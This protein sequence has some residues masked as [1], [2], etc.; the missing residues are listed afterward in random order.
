MQWKNLYPQN[1]ILNKMLAKT[2]VKMYVKVWRTSSD[3]WWSGRAWNWRSP[4]ST[5]QFDEAAKM[6]GKNCEVGY[7]YVVRNRVCNDISHNGLVNLANNTTTVTEVILSLR[8]DRARNNQTADITQ[9]WCVKSKWLKI[10]I[11]IEHI[12]WWIF[13][14]TLQVGCKV[15]LLAW[16]VVCLSHLIC[17]LSSVRSVCDASAIVI[18][19]LSHLL[20]W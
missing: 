2:V 5:N 11:Y 14:R 6:I 18:E 20:A 15:R 10:N 12:K 9:Q 3:M 19:L 1:K 4:R 16:Y 17:R 7:V 8:Y 13:S